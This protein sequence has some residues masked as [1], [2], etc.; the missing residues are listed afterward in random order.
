MK[1]ENRNISENIDSIAGV[2]LEKDYGR[3]T[4][5]EK[6]LTLLQRL[7]EATVDTIHLN[8]TSNKLSYRELRNSMLGFR[9]T[10]RFKTDWAELYRERQNFYKIL[11]KLKAQGLIDKKTSDGQSFWKISNEGL[12]YLNAKPKYKKTRSKFPIVVSYD[13]PEKI[14]KERDRLREILKI[15][16]FWVMHKS[17]WI[18]QTLIPEELM[19]EWRERKILNYIHIF[20]IGKSGTLKKIV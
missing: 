4:T 16:D 17:V 14:R 10:P 5:I 13:I 6:I 11:S 3:T 18:G 8:L 15:L 9:Q 12:G 19:K 2:T 20:E 7:T 1:K